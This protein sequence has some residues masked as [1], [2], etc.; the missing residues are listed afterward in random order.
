MTYTRKLVEVAL[1]P[2][3]ICPVPRPKTH[4]PGPW[5]RVAAGP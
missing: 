1:Q 3:A 2:N 4:S 5:K